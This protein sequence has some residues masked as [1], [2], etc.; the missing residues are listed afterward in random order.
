MSEA[1]SDV[2]ARL[3]SNHLA[4]DDVGVGLAGKDI[5]ADCHTYYESNNPKTLNHGYLLAL[6]FAFPAHA[7]H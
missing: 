7:G 2:A 5:S 1:V 6:A 4:V 3:A